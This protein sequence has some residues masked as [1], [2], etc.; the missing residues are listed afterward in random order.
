MTAV[1]DASCESITVGSTNFHTDNLENTLT[2]T[3]NG[4]AHDVDI[5]T[6][7]TTTFVLDADALDLE[8]LPNGVYGLKLVTTQSDSSTKTESICRVLLCGEECEVLDLYTDQANLDKILAYN[9]LLVVNNCVSCSCDV[10]TML[11]N[12]Y[13][14]T[15]DVGD[16]NC[17]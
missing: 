13:T 10:A 9:G 1:V 17:N 6:T 4:T 16:C 8:S 5:P 7:T 11:Y 3:I 2:V 15:E 12:T 14:D